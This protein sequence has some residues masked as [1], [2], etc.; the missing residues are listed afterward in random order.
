M[1]VQAIKEKKKPRQNA[2]TLPYR[3]G[4]K[5]RITL[6]NEPGV[7]RNTYGIVISTD[8]DG[9][10]PVLRYANLSGLPL[11]EYDR[12][13][14]RNEVILEGDFYIH[15]E[16]PGLERN[17]VKPLGILKPDD[18]KPIKRVLYK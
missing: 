7:F 10:S 13:V 5:V 12:C 9:Y 6:V 17:E 2:E 15:N 4:D 1:V 3:I 11:R 16:V 18:E 14:T 8:C